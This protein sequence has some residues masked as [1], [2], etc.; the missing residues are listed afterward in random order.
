LW[1]LTSG[2]RS[3]GQLREHLTGGEE[4]TKEEFTTRLQAV[5]KPQGSITTTS[6]VPQAES[7]PTLA[8]DV[9]NPS[10]SSS[11]AP[12]PATTTTSSLTATSNPAAINTYLA[13][14]AR[15][16]KDKTAKEA[17]EAAARAAAR[18]KAKG[19]AKAL[20]A[21]IAA[22]ASSSTKSAQLSAAAHARKRK[23]DEKAE[24]HRIQALIENDRAERK[25][26]D[27]DRKK[28]AEE[29][30]RMAAGEAVEEVGETRPGVSS[31][32]GKARA[33][34]TGSVHLNI[35]LFDGGTIRASF[36]HT[37]TLHNVREWIDEELAATEQKHPPYTFK[38]ILPPAP[39]RAISVS[40]EGAEL[41]D[42]DLA[43]SATLVLQPITGYAEAYSG[44][45]GG[46]LDAVV[47][48]AKGLIGTAV[49][50]V[51]GV[52][53]YVTGYGAQ[54][55]SSN[56]LKGEGRATGESTGAG[57]ARVRTLADQR[58][59]RGRDQ[60]DDDRKQFYNGNQTN[61]EPRRDEGKD[62]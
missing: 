20:D 54:A 5:L 4:L 39:S 25:A 49:G 14:T 48:G 36:P 9:S 22:G 24:L 53:G 60:R 35:R 2:F 40:E 7:T 6:T 51:G 52:L 56:H 27:E 55:P 50:V 21:E 59:E 46:V 42:I 34:P 23:E 18:S 41:A 19:K 57:D 11:P 45:S 16:E 28:A 31:G 62:D 58:H 38:H 33:R 32:K 17:A 3:N 1:V 30:R 37:A 29:R 43:P 8:A 12:Q 61:F 15:L 44:N 10:Q 26:R 47:G 13:D